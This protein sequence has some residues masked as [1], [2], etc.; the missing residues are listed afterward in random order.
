[1]DD[2][3]HSPREPTVP[4]SDPPDQ[5]APLI[6]ATDLFRGHREVWITLHGERYR[7]RITRR[8]RLILQK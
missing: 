1:M 3:D 8:N 5:D 4:T 2:R 6:D 7:L